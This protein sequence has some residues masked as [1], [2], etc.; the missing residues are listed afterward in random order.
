[1]G[2]SIYTKNNQIM[3]YFTLYIPTVAKSLLSIHFPLYTFPTKFYYIILY[4]HIFFCIPQYSIH[5]HSFPWV[6]LHVPMGSN[7]SLPLYSL[8]RLNANSVWVSESVTEIAECKACFTAKMFQVRFSIISFKI[9]PMGKIT[10]VL[11]LL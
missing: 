6:S 10:E 9:G 7:A 3:P 11:M 2:A 8:R 1:M 4:S 5:E